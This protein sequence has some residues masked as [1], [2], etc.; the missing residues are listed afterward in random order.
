MLFVDVFEANFD[1]FRESMPLERTLAALRSELRFPPFF[2]LARMGAAI[3]GLAFHLEQL[4][5]DIEFCR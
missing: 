3:F 2:E 1:I 4:E 5:S